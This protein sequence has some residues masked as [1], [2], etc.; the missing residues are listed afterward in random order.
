MR[1]MPQVGPSTPNSRCHMHGPVG[2]GIRSVG[3]PARD[4]HRGQPEQR[5]GERGFGTGPAAHEPGHGGRVEEHRGGGHRER[6]RV[7][8]RNPG[9]DQR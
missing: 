1:V 4:Q 9:A 6:D 8:R 7:D 3:L 5:R 2:S